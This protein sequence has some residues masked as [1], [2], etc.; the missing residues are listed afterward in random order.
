AFVRSGGPPL[1]GGSPY[2]LYGTASGL[3]QAMLRRRDRTGVT[4]YGIPARAME[5]FAPLVER[6][7]GR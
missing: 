1:I 4:S 5:A 2:L 7:A 6:L 3:E